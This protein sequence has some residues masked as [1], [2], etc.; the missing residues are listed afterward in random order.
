MKLLLALSAVL[1]LSVPVF[2]DSHAE[3]KAMTDK[4]EINKKVSPYS[5]NE[6]M[7]K[8][9]AI[10]KKKSF[11]VFARIDHQKNAEGAELKMAPAQVLIF[12]N[13]KGGTMLMND[14]IRVSLDLPLRVVVYKDK[15]DKVYIAYHEPVAMVKGYDLEGHKVVGALTDGLG[16]LTSAAIAE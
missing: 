9:E 12:G 15:D 10:V 7:D 5:V 16:K 2:A 3:K 11:D 1:I 14:D 4:V 13:P 6:T 8:F